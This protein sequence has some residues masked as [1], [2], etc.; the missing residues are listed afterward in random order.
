MIRRMIGF[1]AVLGL[2]AAVQPLCAQG[3]GMAKTT[4]TLERKLPALM[5]LPGNTIRVQVTGHA[6]QA[7]LA[8]DLGALLE[9]E[10]LKDD[11]QLRDDET[12][13]AVTVTCQIT[14]YSHPAP[15]VTRQPAMGSIPAQNLIRIT[16][17]L[18]VSFQ[19]KAGDGRMLGS[20]NISVKY[21]QEFDSSGNN[22]SQGIMKTMTNPFH[23]LKGSS[24]TD[25]EQ[26]KPPTDSELRSKLLDDAV[27]QMAEQIV[28]TTESI[29][30]YLAKD[31]GAI[32][33][34]D[35]E[36]EAGLWERAMETFETAPELPK[37]EDDAYRLYNSGVAYEALGYQA[38]DA[39]TALKFLDQAAIDYG[40]A[41]DAKSSEKY[42]LGP[43]KRIETAIAHYKKLED[44]QNAPPPTVAVSTPPPPTPAALARSVP[45]A[46]PPASAAHG[47]NNAQI[48][49]M[50][51]AGV[52]DAT[53]AQTVRVARAVDFDLSLA[54]QNQLKADGVSTTVL[55]AMKERW[56]KEL[57]SGK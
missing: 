17:S 19:A 40:K 49:A 51:K 24:G 47:L 16:G 46:D 23:R 21:D 53:I 54:A 12:S 13:P 37:K 10:L 4:V 57:T 30:V 28:N 34:G 39:K 6:D 11:P 31:K 5:V 7:D 48:V 29:Q 55:H 33:E 45:A 1:A 32:E 18:N 38:S 3:F 43:Q 26:N 14:D 35:K 20:D 22:M 52:D 41:I 27:Q 44:E 9:T 25:D 8:K 36:A 56:A 15:I 2:A 50:V 42:F